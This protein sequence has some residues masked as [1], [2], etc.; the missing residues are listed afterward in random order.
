MTPFLSTILASLSSKMAL[1]PL[2]QMRPTDHKRPRDCSYLG[3]AREGFTAA[4]GELRFDLAFHPDPLA[5][6]GDKVVVG[7][8][9]RRRLHRVAGHV[10]LSQDVVAGTGVEAD[11]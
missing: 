7:Q 11:F 8:A 3:A 6:G 1:Y 9:S 5:A 10:D 2:S 4:S